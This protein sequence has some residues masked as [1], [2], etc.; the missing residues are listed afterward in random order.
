MIHILGICAGMNNKVRAV[1]GKIKKIEYLK[2]HK[3]EKTY[4]HPIAIDEASLFF[5]IIRKK[6]MN[7][8][9]RHAC[10]TSD[11]GPLM[12]SAYLPDGLAEV[13]EDRSKKFYLAVQFHPESLY[14][15]DEHM[16]QIFEYFIRICSL[17]K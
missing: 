14:R 13:V 16:N 2:N 10:F 4:A 9:S 3:S 5:D 7:V 8:N 12:G 17:K 6:R 11:A 1:G 15:I